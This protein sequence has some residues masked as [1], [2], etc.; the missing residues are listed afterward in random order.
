MAALNRRVGRRPCLAKWA[1]CLGVHDCGV[2]TRRIGSWLL[3]AGLWVASIAAAVWH[4]EHSTLG[5]PTVLGSP[6][7]IYAQNGADSA[8][9]GT[10][11]HSVGSG[12]FGIVGPDHAPAILLFVVAIVLLIGAFA[13]RRARGGDQPDTN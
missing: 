9:I 2:T 10:M 12:R 6:T 11:L 8:P 7:V 13:I 5:P 3:L 4:G 1:S